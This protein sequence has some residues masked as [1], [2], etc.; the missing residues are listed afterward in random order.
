MLLLTSIHR[1]RGGIVA[2]RR[3]R[4]LGIRLLKVEVQRM[5]WH[6]RWQLRRRAASTVAV[7]SAERCGGNGGEALRRCE[8]LC[9]G[10]VAKRGDGCV[11]PEAGLSSVAP[12]TEGAQC[13]ERAP[14]R[15]DDSKRGI[16]TFT[17]GCVET[18]DVARWGGRCCPRQVGADGAGTCARY[19]NVAAS[20][21]TNQNNRN[22]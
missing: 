20:I 17:A 13:N 19:A 15:C 18:A 5:R 6:P 10:I 8:T 3:H 14:R 22:I 9:W 4:R 2:R 21:S 11:G 12:L 7:H 16:C 1:R